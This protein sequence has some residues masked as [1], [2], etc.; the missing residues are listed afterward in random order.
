MIRNKCV[1]FERGCRLVGVP[2]V[3][4]P[5]LASVPCR[6]Q[7]FTQLR[8]LDFVVLS[9]V[10]CSIASL[11]ILKVGCLTSTATS[12]DRDEKEPD[13][14]NITCSRRTIRFF[15]EKQHLYRDPCPLFQLQAEKAGK[16]LRVEGSYLFRNLSVLHMS[17]VS[18]VAGH[19][20]PLPLLTCRRSTVGSKYF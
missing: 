15:C 11:D 4:V 3:V 2:Y 8:F 6:H 14:P 1:T 17:R 5:R 13:E 7:R 18:L 19:S 10:A 20:Q 12:S 16:A 9:R